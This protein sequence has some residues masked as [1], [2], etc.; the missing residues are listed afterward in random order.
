MAHHAKTS[1]TLEEVT[2]PAEHPWRKLPRI[3]LAVGIVGLIVALA[4]IPVQGDHAYFSYLTNYMYWLSLA[5]GGLWFTILHHLTR[6]GWSSTIRR[7]AENFAISL[8]ILAVLWIPIGMGA[9]EM[10]MDPEAHQTLFHWV[11]APDDPVIAKK[12]AYLNLNFFYLRAVFYLALWSLLAWFYY[13]QSTSQDATGDPKHSRRAQWWAPLAMIAWVLSV[14]F[15]A[16]DWIM[17]LDP[18]WYSTV[19]GVYYFAGCAL[20]IYIGMALAGHLMQGKGLLTE[21][22]TVDH[23]HGI[24]K[25]LF[26][27]V[28]FWSYIAFCQFMLIWYA[29]IPEETLWFA[30]RFEGSWMVVTVVLAL[31]HFVLPFFFLMS[32]HTKRRKQT[33]VAACVWLG[34]LHWIDLYWLIQPV[35]T[36]HHG[37]HG[38]TFGIADLAAF[39][40]IGGIV[41]AVFTRNLAARP[42]VA[43][44][45]PRLGES[46]VMEN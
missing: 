17:S 37:Y 1:L 26:G 16:F 20:A 3:S 22:I 32:R 38:A 41:I 33:L 25:M 10:F 24:G 39:V 31:G 18:H 42:M 19:F 9:S 36:H 46:L 45:D 5:L 40:G 27:F 34:V 8:P 23:Y 2:L 7:L 44:Q 21:A 43:F 13:K 35:Y 12:S 14:T 15:A 29:N 30:H 4:L 6:A 28:V 11:S